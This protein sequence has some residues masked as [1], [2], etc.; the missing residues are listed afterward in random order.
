MKYTKMSIY[1]ISG[2]AIILLIVLTTFGCAMTRQTGWYGQYIMKDVFLKINVSSEPSGAKVY[3]NEVFHGTTPTSVSLKV[4]AQKRWEENKLVSSDG[5]PL[6]ITRRPDWNSLTGVYYYF[7]RA[8]GDYAFSTP[9]A[10]LTVTV[11]Q[12]GYKRETK[13]FKVP[14]IEDVC[15]YWSDDEK[16]TI[17][18]SYNWTAFL[19]RG[20]DVDLDLRLRIKP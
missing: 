8:C 10:N 1:S 16:S 13:E 11:Y 20:P 17:S 4:I 7:G 15:K 9:G 5:K 12:E 18:L 14:N 3:V 2:P 19:Q 6:Q